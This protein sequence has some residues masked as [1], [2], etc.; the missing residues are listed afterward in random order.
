MSERLFVGD[1]RIDALPGDAR[2]FAY[3][4]GLFET[5]RVHRGTVPWWVA[6]RARLGVGAARLR[7][8]LPKRPHRPWS[9]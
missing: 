5:M 6:H 8:P 2:G 7:L 4:D 3:G 9:G 1:K